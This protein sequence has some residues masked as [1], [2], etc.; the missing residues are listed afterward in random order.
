MD[1]LLDL[2]AGQDRCITISEKASIVVGIVLGMRLVGASREQIARLSRVYYEINP[3][4][5]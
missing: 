1:A 3:K 2:D 4:T 5:A